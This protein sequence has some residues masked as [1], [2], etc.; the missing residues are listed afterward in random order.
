MSFFNELLKSKGVAE[1]PTPLWKLKVN[2]DEYESL[3][4]FLSREYLINGSFRGC[5][6][7]LALFYAEW[8][9]RNPG[10]STS[11]TQLI[12]DI[13]LPTTGRAE[14][15]L[16]EN[17]YLVFDPRSRYYI[18][19]VKLIISNRGREFKYSLFYQGGFPMGKACSSRGGVWSYTIKRF[20]KTNLNFEGLAGAKIAK[21]ALKE[22]RNL[23]VD[24]AR[25]RK[26]E[27]MPFVCDE[28]HPWYKKALEG[29]DEGDRERE[30]RPFHIKWFVSRRAGDFI[31]K[32]QITG[33]S[34]LRESFLASHPEILGM[35]SVPVQLFID[36]TFVDTLVEYSPSGKGT[37]F[38]YYDV[39]RT[40]NYDGT[41]KV[42]IRIPGL[43]RSLVSSD[44]DMS[45]PHSFFITSNGDYE[46]GARFGECTS[47]IVFN[48]EWDATEAKGPHTILHSSFN[49]DSY[50]FLTCGVPSDD[51]EITFTIRN[52]RTGEQYTFGSE[53]TP[54]WTEIDILKP[55]NPLIVENLCDFSDPKQVRVLEMEND[56]DEGLVAVPENIYYRRDSHSDW[57]KEFLYGKIQCSVIHADN[58][59]E[60]S[61]YTSPE[62]NVIS[63]GPGFV[64]ETVRYLPKECHYRISWDQ[65]KI[66][67]SDGKAQPDENGIWCFKQEDYESV[68]ALNC[69]PIQGKEFTIHVR[70]V[71][72]DF[73]IYA[74]DGEKVKR[75]E[76]I[77]W[78]EVSSYRYSVRGSSKIDIRPYNGNTF[79]LRVKQGTGDD[80][81]DIPENGSLGL[82]LTPEKLEQYA[83]RA[84]EGQDFSIRYCDFTLMKYPLTLSYDLVNQKLIPKLIFDSGITDPIILE[85]RNRL[86]TNFKGVLLVLNTK[87]DVIDE[88]WRGDDGSYLLPSF[89]ERV[90]II[91]NQR[92]LLRPLVYD[93]GQ[94]LPFSAQLSHGDSLD[95]GSL[96]GNCW[97]SA[98]K[99]LETGLRYDI[100]L[101]DLPWI[102]AVSISPG[103]ALA[104][105]CRQVILAGNDP[106]K[107]TDVRNKMNKLLQ[108]A[109][110]SLG[111]MTREGEYFFSICAPGSFDDEYERWL[112]T[113]G[114]AE[115]SE[116]TWIQ[117]QMWAAGTV[118]KLIT[119]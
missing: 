81:W 60:R 27:G 9:K 29:I 33:P 51:T 3:R 5:A 65:G 32:C 10:E 95:G 77:P 30:A 23:F 102:G 20:V 89:K 114:F 7:E 71:Y 49:G 110:I 13:G 50:T 66:Y 94:V 74:P 85:N 6:K 38:S 107:L 18:P 97:E 48:E 14:E 68:A 116:T 40:I 83:W 53:T 105:Y 117:F 16:K 21:K 78:T 37:F 4:Q 106:S 98:S 103:R 61:K 46:M 87:G 2:D 58:Q 75:Y 8:W 112:Q 113:Y 43:D 25:A 24:A 42:S 70:I 100:P 80:I 93:A 22:Y 99:F 91:C 84:N 19:G 115:T 15:S 96:S 69:F 111:D 73:S 52:K 90:L 62:N 1:C 59:D 104:L 31:I 108:V 34:E 109:N 76:I 64:V 44:F 28:N 88:L 72:R 36:D 67:S 11:E 12:R 79:S 86:V 92:G 26:P 41:S 39:N 35:E 101:K 54:S 45:I 55:Y 82:I 57:T 17:A 56:E 119:E 118:Q 63:V 47:L